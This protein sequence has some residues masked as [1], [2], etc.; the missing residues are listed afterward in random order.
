MYNGM[1][2]GI[3]NASSGQTEISFSYIKNEICALAN[4]N[5]A[6]FRSF[7]SLD[8]TAVSDGAGDVS[9]RVTNTSA[10]DDLQSNLCIR[11]MKN[12]LTI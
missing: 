10:T 12:M 9:L 2:T 5:T 6:A 7:D 1:L 3:Y 4:Q 11:V 8:V